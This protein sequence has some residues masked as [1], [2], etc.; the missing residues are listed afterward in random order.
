MP[1]NALVASA[2]KPAGP[3]T[4]ASSP[5][6]RS[7]RTS[8]RALSTAST[9]IFSSPSARMGI[10]TTAA[11]PSCDRTNGGNVPTPAMSA[12]CSRWR[13]SATAARPSAS[14]PPPSRKTAI[15]GV[16]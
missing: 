9:R 7:W 15:A 8:S 16:S 11:L 5:G 3:V 13:A 2:E 4:R 12:L 10:V 6:G 14:S 1:S